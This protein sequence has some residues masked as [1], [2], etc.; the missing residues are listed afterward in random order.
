MGSHARAGGADRRGAR[1]AARRA[2]RSGARPSRYRV[3]LLVGA[4]AAALYARASGRAHVRHGALPRAADRAAP[5]PRRLARPRPARC[6]AR[7]SAAVAGPSRSSTPIVLVVLDELP[8]STLADAD[9]RIDAE[10]F[11]NF[12][13][14]ARE[15][16]WYRNA[17]TVNDSTAAA[18]PAQL[19]GEQPRAG[20][21]PTA[22]DHPRSLFT[23]F[24]RSHELTVIEPITAVCPARLCDDVRP[25]TGDR[26]RSL[27]SDL[28]VV[29]QHLLLPAD[30]RDGLPAVDRMWEGFETDPVPDSGEFARG[31]NLQ[32]RRARAAR[33]RRRGGRVRAR[34]R[35]AR[36]ARARDRRCVFLH[37]TLPHMPWRYLPDGRRLSDRRQGVPGALEQGL[38]DGAAVAGRPGLPAPRPAGAVRRPAA[39][40]AARRPARPRRVR[41]RGDRGHRR[42]RRAFTTGQP[43]RPVEPRERRRRSRR[44]RSS[45]SCPASPTAASTTA[46]C[47]R[48]TCSRRSPRRPASRC[49]GRSTGSRPTSARSTRRHR[50]TSRTWASRC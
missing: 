5:V 1:A 7:R 26:L 31:A 14:L 36:A 40:Q 15:S 16:T 45:S 43:R 44:S 18:V 46:R 32:A 6:P 41:R 9:G 24:E 30:L 17:T 10:L 50:S 12:A 21:L 20:T 3:A 19:T 35:R 11:P 28:E 25:G 48:S 38:V 39:G 4:G 37:S 23:L 49:H 29:V 13:R 34:D 33:P 2:T 8:Q 27:E 22:R 42:P 47:E